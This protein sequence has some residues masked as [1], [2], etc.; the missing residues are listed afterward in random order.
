[1][2]EKILQGLKTKY[3]NLGFG[4]KAFDGVAE[5]LSHNVTEEEQI[6]TSLQGVENLLKAF[7][8]EIDN[9]V[10]TAVDKVKKEKPAGGD[11]PKTEPENSKDDT[12][13]WAKALIEE[14]KTLKEKLA[15]IEGSNVTK[16]R[17]QTL[18][19]KLKDAPRPFKD[20]ILKD[21]QRMKFDSDEDFTSYLDDTATDME[22]AV[23]EFADKGL[24][25]IP[26]PF[27]GGTNGSSVEAAI[28]KHG[29]ARTA[30]AKV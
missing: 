3:K 2:K 13:A 5:F 12:P 19:E 30:Q 16:T 1:M 25:G 18:S 7:Q 10:N 29:E 11:P 22:K 26:K 23:Q 24:G 27:T 9:R 8:S 14:S 15:A 20:K 21:F 28:K 17:Q 6:E 4:E